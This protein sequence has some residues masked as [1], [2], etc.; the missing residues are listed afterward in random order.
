MVYIFAQISPA[1]YMSDVKGTLPAAPMA[2]TLLHLKIL[3]FAT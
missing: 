2:W 3:S 1:F